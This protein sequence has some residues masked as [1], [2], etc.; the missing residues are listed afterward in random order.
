MEDQSLSLVVSRNNL[1][2]GLWGT[3]IISSRPALL[4]R[5]HSRL[6]WAI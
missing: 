3:W 5:V 4:Y 2:L 6:A 1:E